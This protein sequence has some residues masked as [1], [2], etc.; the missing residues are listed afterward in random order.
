MLRTHVPVFQTNSNSPKLVLQSL[1]FPPGLLVVDRPRI[2]PI[3]GPR[4]CKSLLTRRLAA[5]HEI[6]SCGVINGLPAIESSLER[7]L[8]LPCISR[9]RRWWYWYFSVRILPND[10]HRLLASEVV[11]STCVFMRSMHKIYASESSSLQTSSVEHR[12]QSYSISSIIIKP[13]VASKKL[14]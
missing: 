9:S 13:P 11:T 2:W 5:D 4:K 1:M 6:W 7:R 3:D 12:S 14:V 10:L 8:I